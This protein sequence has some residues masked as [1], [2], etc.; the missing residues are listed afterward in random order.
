M[1]YKWQ[2]AHTIPTI[3]IPV[4]GIA[5]NGYSMLLSTDTH[6]SVK[7]LLNI[8]TPQKGQKDDQNQECPEI[9][10]HNF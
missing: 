4:L 9:G 2:L 7:E 1:R 6:V 8:K 3:L 5:S 10:K